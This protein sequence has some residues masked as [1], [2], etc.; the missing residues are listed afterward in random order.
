MFFI[1]LFASILLLIAVSLI[2]PQFNPGGL[3][4]LP[5]EGVL[6]ATIG[7]GV[8]S[9]T[10]WC[11]LNHRKRS[12]AVSLSAPLGMMISKTLFA[13]VNLTGLGIIV[14]YLGMVG[15]ELLLPEPRRTSGSDKYNQ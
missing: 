11:R 15:L 3:I 5:V 4:V 2:I 8:E 10:R 7:L 12:F 6:I 9:L 1:H 14:M 13:G